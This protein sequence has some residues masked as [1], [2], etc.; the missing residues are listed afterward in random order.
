MRINTKGD[1]VNGF[2]LAERVL[3][4]HLLILIPGK[5]SLQFVRRALRRLAS[6]RQNLLAKLFARRRLQLAAIGG[7]H[8]AE[9]I[10]S[11]KHC[12]SQSPPAAL[13]DFRRQQVLELVRQLAQF[14]ETARGGISLERVHSTAHR[15]DDVGITRMLFQLQSFLIEHLQ[16]FCCALKE[17]FAEFGSALVGEKAHPCT[18]SRWYAVPLSWW[19]MRYLSESPKRLSACPT[20]R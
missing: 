2:R 13:S 15:P 8:G 12:L 16:Q 10:G 5:A 18:S 3:D 9:R 6:E 17:E 1:V 19:I 4:H 20:S 11:N 7:K 14:L